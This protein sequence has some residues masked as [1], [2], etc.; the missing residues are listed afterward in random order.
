[1]SISEIE[2]T[3]LHKESLENFLYKNGVPKAAIDKSK[4]EIINKQPDFYLYT[5]YVK[6]IDKK[7]KVYL[8]DVCCPARDLNHN[9]TWFKVLK[10]AIY[11]YPKA[12]RV[13]MNINSTYNLLSLLEDFKYQKLKGYY[14]NYEGSFSLFSFIEIQDDSEDNKLIQVGDGNHRMILAKV[15]GVEYV[16]ADKI[17]VYIVNQQKKIVYD[18]IKHKEAEIMEYVSNS[19]LFFFNDN[20][21]ISIYCKKGYSLTIYEPFLK[22]QQD[23]LDVM[24]QYLELLRL[25]FLELK[26][27][28]KDTL[29]KHHLYRYLH[30][31]IYNNLMKRIKKHR[32]LI[33][34]DTTYTEIKRITRLYY[35]AK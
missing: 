28:E 24:K 7:Q 29:E 25:T 15:I 14:E 5:E 11:G 2:H 30:K 27:L 18:Q 1:M 34:T 20:F 4:Q 9:T 6:R 17:D 35:F 21:Q 22:I 13:S 19:N 26:Q 31:S 12:H 10:W 23:N 8:K 32:V 16:Y 33:S 3:L